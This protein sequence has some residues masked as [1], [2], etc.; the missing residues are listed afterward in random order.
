VSQHNFK[1]NKHRIPTILIR[2]YT[3]LHVKEKRE[4][5]HASLGYSR[6]H[7]RPY[8]CTSTPFL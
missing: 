7:E 8:A 4:M 1:E 2:A 5:R 6:L 3:R